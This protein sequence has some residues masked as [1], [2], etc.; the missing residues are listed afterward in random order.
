VLGHI[1]STF[2]GLLAEDPSAVR[3]EAGQIICRRSSYA[4]AGRHHAAFLLSLRQG[5]QTCI[6]GQRRGP[7]QRFEVRARARSWALGIIKPCIRLPRCSGA[8]KAMRRQH[9]QAAGDA[10]GVLTS[11]TLPELL[12]RS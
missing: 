2:Q 9:R 5:A 3:A 12:K 8:A 10:E 4:A 6:V 1:C 7:S 11:A